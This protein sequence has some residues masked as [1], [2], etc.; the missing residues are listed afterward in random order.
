MIYTVEKRLPLCI[1]K[2]GPH[3]VEMVK[4]YVE[5]RWRT[6][7][8]ILLI[9]MAPTVRDGW[10]EYI[11]SK[12]ALTGPFKSTDIY[13][14]CVRTRLESTY[15]KLGDIRNLAPLIS[16]EAHKLARTKGLYLKLG[17]VILIRSGI[18][19]VIRYINKQGGT[20]ISM[21]SVLWPL[22]RA[23]NSTNGLP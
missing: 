8:V 17:K 4:I 14:R 22:F 23:C 21:F 5:E 1:W 3:E 11:S 6:H 10:I 19:T 13:N 12:N 2:I 9:W 20:L 15:R 16:A 7:F 18:T